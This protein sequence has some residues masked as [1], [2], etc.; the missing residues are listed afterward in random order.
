MSKIDSKDNTKNNSIDSEPNY[1]KGKNDALHI[2]PLKSEAIRR[3]IAKTGLRGGELSL[4]SFLAVKSSDFKKDGSQIRKSNWTNNKLCDAVNLSYRQIQRITARLEERA[5]L[6]KEP[7]LGIAGNKG[8]VAN[9]FTVTSLPFYI[10]RKRTLELDILRLESKGYPAED[11]REQLEQVDNHIKF[12]LSTDDKMSPP[13]DKMEATPTTKLPHTTSKS[14]SNSK[15]I[16]KPHCKVSEV[17]DKLNSIKFFE[18]HAK[19]TK[20]SIDTS[21][22]QKR[23]VKEIIETDSLNL[24]IKNLELE[25]KHDCLQVKPFAGGKHSLR[26]L[27]INDL[28]DRVQGQHRAVRADIKQLVR[29][30]PNYSLEGVIRRYCQD[31]G[32]EYRTIFEFYSGAAAQKNTI[33]QTQK[34]TAQD[35]FAQKNDRK[36]VAQT[37]SFVRSENRTIEDYKTLIAEHFKAKGGKEAIAYFTNDEPTLKTLD[38][39]RNFYEIFVRTSP[40]HDF[41]Q[42]GTD[43]QTSFGSIAQPEIDFSDLPDL[44]F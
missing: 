21:S 11:K 39:A 38:E 20:Q 8:V 25:E 29:A 6:I 28:L 15:E 27:L 3:E 24:A 16:I 4:L 23:F 33:A 17:T 18:R 1:S 34:T 22:A 36:Q 40:Q 12:L 32:F 37:K 44:P 2:P 14:T 5:F 41:A 9:T 30:I 35:S 10:A 13:H 26:R 7:L 19:A 42:T 31:E 43:A